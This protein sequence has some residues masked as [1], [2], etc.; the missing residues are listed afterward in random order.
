MPALFSASAGMR[1][2][3]R[4]ASRLCPGS[5]AR[6]RAPPAC[7]TVRVAP[8]TPSPVAGRSALGLFETCRRTPRMSVHRGRPEVIAAVGTPRLTQI[9]HSTVSLSPD[10][11]QSG[12]PAC[13]SVLIHDSAV[14]SLRFWRRTKAGSMRAWGWVCSNCRIISR[15]SSTR[16]RSTS[17]TAAAR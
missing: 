9:G 10:A 17:A 8:P 7:C 14:N 11:V 3:K 4:A 1:F 6:R 2:M 12:R 16:P 5:C 13:C 15:A